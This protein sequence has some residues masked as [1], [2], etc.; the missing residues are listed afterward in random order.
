M[1]V[2]VMLLET[3]CETA[4]RELQGRLEQTTPAFHA[5]LIG[6]AGRC[7]PG[8]VGPAEMRRWMPEMPVA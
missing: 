4:A 2:P 5:K 7:Q 1:L 3:G 8:R 6:C